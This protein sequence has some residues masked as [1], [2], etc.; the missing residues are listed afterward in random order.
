MI[1]IEVII[2]ECVEEV[3]E[4]FMIRCGGQVRPYD[5]LDAVVS[6]E[7]SNTA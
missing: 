3:I 2:V 6:V 4:R 1:A 7:T 5:H